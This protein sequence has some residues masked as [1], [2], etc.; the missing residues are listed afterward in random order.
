MRPLAR[1]LTTKSRLIRFLVMKNENSFTQTGL[2]L[3]EL[4]TT[5]LIAATIFAISLPHIAQSLSKSRAKSDSKKFERKLIETMTRAQARGIEQTIKL[6]RDRYTISRPERKQKLELILLT[7]PNH[8]TGSSFPKELHFYT[9]GTVSPATIQFQDG[10]SS[11]RVVLSLR[12][13]ITRECK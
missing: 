4:L 1:K 12:G 9:N 7:N 11:C 10:E 13:R 5:L 2:S 6:E 8:I 3:I